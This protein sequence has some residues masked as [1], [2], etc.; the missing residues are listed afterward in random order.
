MSLTVLKA[1]MALDTFNDLAARS[2]FKQTATM[3]KKTP[4]PPGAAKPKMPIKTPASPGAAKPKA[5]AGFKP[6]SAQDPDRDPET[7]GYRM[8]VVREWAKGPHK[9]VAEGKWLLQ[10][11]KGGK[12]QV[13]VEGKGWV[14]A[15]DYMK[16]T[17]A[18]AKAEKPGDKPEAK[19]GKPKLVGQVN[20]LIQDLKDG[21]VSMDQAKTAI[22]GAMKRVGKKFRELDAQATSPEDKKHL[23]DIKERSKNLVETRRMATK[24]D[25]KKAMIA[26]AQML[27]EVVEG[28]AAAVE[29]KKGK[30]EGVKPQ[31]KEPAKEEKVPT[32]KGYIYEKSALSTAPWE[33]KIEE[34]E[35]ALTA[36]SKYRDNAQAGSRSL[37]YFE[38][39]EDG[40]RSVYK[41]DGF[42]PPIGFMRPI[43]L[44]PDVSMGTRE[45]AAFLAD[46]MLGFG[47]VPPTFTKDS[48]IPQA[49][50]QEA[51]DSLLGHGEVQQLGVGSDEFRMLKNAV[52]N[53]QTDKDEVTGSTQQFIEGAIGAGSSTIPYINDRYKNDNKFRFNMQKKAVFDYVTGA[54]DG[55]LG[56]IMFSDEKSGS[57]VFG[58]DNGM[59]FPK[60]GKRNPADMVFY[61]SA[62]HHFVMDLSDGKIDSKIIKQL[63]TVNQK[64]SKQEMEK[65]GL[66]SEATGMNARIRMIVDS[67]A[68]PN[69][70]NDMSE[71]IKERQALEEGATASV[72]APKP[73]KVVPKPGISTLRQSLDPLE[74]LKRR[75]SEKKMVI[76]IV[77]KTPKDK[78]VLATYSFDGKKVK[79]VQGAE[80]G[81]A[82]VINLIGI[83]G[84]KAKHYMLDD[85]MDFMHNLLWAFQGS[86]VKAIAR[87]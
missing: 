34:I 36:P 57:E 7:G 2:L 71:R 54:T 68:L 33:G 55:H 85:G 73:K 47:T 10:R 76:D 75:E 78:K 52:N 77:Y 79:C 48:V 74:M 81:L 25:D 83:V 39:A 51:I 46:R 16:K 23:D 70:R 65:L 38:V 44:N 69:V 22:G 87:K 4:P 8:G 58:I 35:K 11:M 56:N 30:E 72:P 20:Q 27:Q 84:M 31:E 60:P 61:V 49:E 29:R 13:F 15:A 28:V 64:Q 43:I 42:A 12:E 40:T 32:G 37:V 66:G 24:N 86:Y 14:S 17:P 6:P 63:Q 1:Q 26:A 5:P 3:P 80:L 19:A 50:R 59:N 62:A 18:G 82:S 67:G 53:P 21:K 9:K 41:P 45:S